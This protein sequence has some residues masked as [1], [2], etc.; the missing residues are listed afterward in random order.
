MMD[1]MQVS[2]TELLKQFGELADK[3]L[4]EPITITKNGRA[5]L[6]L[7]SAVEYERLKKRDRQV[8]TPAD[9]TPQELAALA[10]AEVPAEYSHLDAELKDPV[11]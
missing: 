6:V 7:L 4:T 1:K 2:T 10:A 9:L 5:R 3:A 11:R 8:I